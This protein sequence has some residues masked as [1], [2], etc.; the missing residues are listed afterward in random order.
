MSML[1]LYGRYMKRER[2]E[3][4]ALGGENRGNIWQNRG[5]TGVCAMRCCMV[6]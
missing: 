1:K 4:Y 3:T 6:K 2:G 5:E